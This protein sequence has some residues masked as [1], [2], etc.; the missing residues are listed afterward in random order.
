MVTF[1]SEELYAK[2]YGGVMICG[3]DIERYN[4]EAFLGVGVIMSYVLLK[5]YSKRQRI[6]PNSWLEQG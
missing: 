2:G 1:M 4:V 6:L 5:G 3:R